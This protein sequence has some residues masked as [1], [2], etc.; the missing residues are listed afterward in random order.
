MT[1]TAAGHRNI[2]ATHRKTLELTREPEI[3]PRA[4]CVV[5]VGAELDEPSALGLRGRVELTLAVGGLREAVRGRI[6][7]AFQPGD[8]LIARRAD[9]V[10]RDALVI[11]ADRAAAD[12]P[13]PFVAALADPAARVAVTVTELPDQPAPG[14][15][16][17]APRQLGR[18]DRDM[19][20][21]NDPVADLRVRSP[22]GDAAAARAVEAL[23]RGQRVELIADFAADPRAGGLVRRA[24][25]D[26][27][28][29]L[30]AAQLPVIDA[31]LAAAGLP[32]AAET[33]V[34]T[35]VPAEHLDRE[36]RVT[37]ATHGAVVLD[38]GTPRE[39][40][41]AWRAGERLAI[42]GVRGR[43]AAFAV[44]RSAG[45][46]ERARAL[47]AAGAST[48]DVAR[49]LREETGLPH[50]RAYEL[51]LDLTAETSNVSRPEPRTS[52]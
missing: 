45:S 4:T 20:G 48:R 25:D 9:A 38:H 37:G 42:P 30:P 26:G 5:A 1:G 21:K 16:I 32:R 43:T 44:H 28:D 40:Y 50:R 41:V 12:L 8:P 13:R 15:L 6:N 36:L 49:A 19:G 14:C 2:R 23:G 3:G 34:A 24:W 39:Q 27:H 17:V 52:R 46:T 51:A 22:L 31:V 33:T 47:A 10:T 18:V 29:V 35:N 7:P 11:D